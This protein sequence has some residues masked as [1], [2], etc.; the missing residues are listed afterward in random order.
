MFFNIPN[1]DAFINKRTARYVGKIAR[2][3]DRALPKKFLAAWINKP[4]KNGA[5]QLT[6][7]SNFAR[8]INGI[9]PQEQTLSNCSTPL[10]E[11]LPLAKNE[12]SWLFYIDEYFESCLRPE[13]SDVES[14]EDED[15][16]TSSRLD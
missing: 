4:R 1:I 13:E 3:D 16:H 12:K 15:E 9:L 14:E 11:W 10:K 8:A 5:P 6:Y 2:S 7:N